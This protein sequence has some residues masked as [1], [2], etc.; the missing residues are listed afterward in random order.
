MKTASWG[1]TRSDAQLWECTELL[2]VKNGWPVQGEVGPIGE[3][4]GRS[5]VRIS[6]P[7]P[8]SPLSSTHITCRWASVSSQM[9]I[10]CCSLKRTC[11]TLIL[12]VPNVPLGPN[13]DQ[14][15]VQVLHWLRPSV[16]EAELVVILDH[17]IFKK[18]LKIL[19]TFRGEKREKER[20]RNINVWEIW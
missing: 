4:N 7:L 19:F 18:I 11:Y 20:E 6:I 8:S 14:E 10:I 12:V 2:C 9:L 1:V 15:Y 3:E 5:L 13:R 17:R 16:R